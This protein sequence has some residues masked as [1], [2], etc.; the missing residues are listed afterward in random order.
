MLVLT[1][2]YP[3]WQGDPEPGFVHELAKRLTDRFRVMVLGPHAP[4]APARDILDGVEV[5]RYRYAPQRWETL[6]NDGGI[7]TNLRNSPWKLLLVPGFVLAQAITAWRLCRH[8]HVD[9]IHAHWLIPQG[10]IAACWRFVPGHR[11]PFVATSHGADLYA[12]NGPMLNLLKRFVCG[13][14]AALTVVSKAMQNELERIGVE[15]GKSHVQPMGVDLMGRF[16]PT[17]GVR[18]ENE[19]LFVG[20]LVEKKGL[21]VL[22]EALPLI[23]RE[24]PQA[25]LTVAGFGPEEERL[26]SQARDLGVGQAVDF[27]GAVPQAQ[28]P[29][30]YRRASLLVAP[31][32]EASGGDR[33][34]LGL[35][36]IEAIACGCPVVVGDLPA[37]R[38]V[39]GDREDAT[40]L[41]RP[42]DSAALAKAVLRSMD[43]RD[44]TAEQ[45]VRL[46]ERLV[47][48]F[49]WGHVAKGYE[50]ILLRAC[51]ET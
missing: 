18:N 16:K 30:L 22:L 4:G 6:V 25:R 33:E 17:G 31:F 20:R 13:R 28:L 19:L 51:T 2:T 48:R 41:V 8:F 15:P 24:R 14:A 9:V 1:S 3:R 50:S 23:L 38:D 12:L 32:V 43:E 21:H 49:D 35:V 36:T 34:G 40:M 42:G 11:T 27:L 47:A 7:V 39:L 26:R 46:R 5:H 45:A 37:V 29:E 44:A 10:L